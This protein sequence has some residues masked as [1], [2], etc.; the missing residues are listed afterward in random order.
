MTGIPCCAIFSPY[1]LRKS[2]QIRQGHNTHADLRSE[3]KNSLQKHSCGTQS[4]E[5]FNFL[6]AATGCTEAR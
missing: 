3:D 2:H 5:T 4:H 1:V 6:Q